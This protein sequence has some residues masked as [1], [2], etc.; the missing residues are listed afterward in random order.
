MDEHNPKVYVF[1]YGYNSPGH[2]ARLLG[3]SVEDLLVDCRACT[4]RG[5]KRT[6]AGLDSEF[7]HRSV[8]AIVPD[9]ESSINS[10][11]FRIPMSELKYVDEFEEYPRF[12]DRVIVQLEDRHGEHFEG[13]V[14]VMNKNEDFAYPWASYLSGVALT[15]ATYHYLHGEEFDHVNFKIEVTDAHTGSHHDTFHQRLCL[16]DYPEPVRSK[17]EKATA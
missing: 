5:Y 9:P 14:Y 1:W 3:M 2:I 15:M 6:F 10:Y 7:S 11:A 13:H 17:L 4:L 8:C 16:L 12:Y